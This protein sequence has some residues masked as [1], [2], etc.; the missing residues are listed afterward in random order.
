MNL[1][2]GCNSRKSAFFFY[3]L[4][5]ISWKKSKL[6]CQSCHGWGGWGRGER[7]KASKAGFNEMEAQLLQ[8]H[9]E[10]PGSLP[11]K[12]SKLTLGIRRL[13]EREKRFCP[14][15]LHPTG[16]L[17]DSLK[18]KQTAPEAPPTW[19]SLLLAQYCGK[20]IFQTFFIFQTLALKVVV[21]KQS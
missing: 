10:P 3:K 12:W 4:A 15:Y 16:I 6:C 17:R 2:G 21:S 14:I 11:Q 13:E 1:F 8:G 20:V 18:G 9:M 19:K 7:G 5:Q